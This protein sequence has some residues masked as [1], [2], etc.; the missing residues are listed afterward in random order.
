MLLCLLASCLAPY[1]KPWMPQDVR[2]C[3]RGCGLGWWRREGWPRRLMSP[4][5]RHRQRRARYFHD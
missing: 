3:Y 5:P 1:S 2:T 4:L